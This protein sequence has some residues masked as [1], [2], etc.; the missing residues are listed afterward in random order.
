LLAR[1]VANESE[2]NFFSING[3]EIMSKFYGESEAR[4]REIF[5]QAQQNAPSIIFIDELDAIA[6]KREEVT[7]EVERR[8][9]AQLLALMDGLGG[10][11]NVIVIGATNRPGA[12]DPALRRPGRFDREIEIGV[13]DKAARFEILQIHTRG[14]PLAEDVDLKKLAEMTH[15]YTGADLAA[16]GRET[17]M[18]ALR[19][20]L[21]EINLE[22]ERIPPTV[23]E[24][25]EIRMEDFSNAY[26]E[27]TPTAMREVYIEVPTV[28]W[29]DIG[30]L[31]GV[32]QELREAV[33]W[34]LK[35]PE[36]FVRLGIRPPKGI[37]LYGPPGCG[38]TLLARAVA[39]E[40][41]ANFITIKG[42]EVFSKW[43]G[44]SEK[45]IREVFRKARMAAPAVIFF[46]EFDSLVPRRGLGFADS[47]VSER[48][49][50]QL[51]TEM[52]GILNLEDIVIVA[53]TNRP[54]MVDTA[55]LR[56]GR[57]DRLIYVP[58]PDEEARK[59]ILK[60]Y[61]TGMPLTKDININDLAKMTVNY[62]GA[63]I[64]GLCREAALV[65]LRK[66]I[67]AKE[68]TLADFKAATEQVGP[69]IKPEME[70]WYKSFMRQVRQ[71][72]K[73]TPLVA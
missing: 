26:K 1:A 73:P 37:L 54:D 69:T 50:S 43:V 52:D 32:K 65:A 20:Y 59:Q 45:A 39:T 2:A 48:V 47:G 33:E 46:D 53:A 4:L 18:K 62:S 22:E 21:P 3:P 71:V 55:V 58:E 9:V 25:M 27:V 56:P 31:A 35:N 34:P 36:V 8:V 16:L 60:I 13:P 7:G 6:P 5:Q 67:S 23:L 10:R 24:K 42:P 72:Q 44:E 61:T 66:N 70:N 51:L 15:G 40:S 57:F 63:D 12:L 68:V 17:A 38:K 14:M 30:G 41:E 29:E 64:N 28:H 19:R 11:G 49:I